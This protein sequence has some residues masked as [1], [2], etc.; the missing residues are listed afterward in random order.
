MYHSISLEKRLRCRRRLSRGERRLANIGSRNKGMEMGRHWQHSRHC[1]V[2]MLLG[3]VGC[4]PLLQMTGV[5]ATANCAQ[6][7]QLDQNTGQCV[8]RPTPPKPQPRIASRA[9]KSNESSVGK[10]LEPEAALDDTLKDDT[11][12][13]SGLVGVIRANSYPCDTVSAL[14]QFEASNG[15]R[16]ACDGFRHRYDIEDKGGR[17]IVTAK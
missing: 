1:W 9:P 15:F 11:K 16:L 4:A 12:L 13:L 7:Q 14:R 2:V 5:A 17:W 8:A 6:G 3:L 10:L